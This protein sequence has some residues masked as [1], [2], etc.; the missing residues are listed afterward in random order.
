MFTIYL[1]MES[2]DYSTKHKAYILCFNKN[3][4]Y[5][6][7]IATLFKV[8]GNLLF[9]FRLETLLAG[10]PMIILFSH[11][12]FA[13]KAAA[14]FCFLAYLLFDMLLD[15]LNPRYQEEKI[16][17]V[18]M[19]QMLKSPK[20]IHRGDV[21][22][23]NDSFLRDASGRRLLLRGINVGGDSKIPALPGEDSH[24]TQDICFVGRPFPLS[25]ADEHFQRLQACGFTLVRLV[26]TWKAVEHAGPGQYDFAYLQ[27]LQELVQIG[28][29]YNMSFIID[30][31]QDVWSRFTGG[32]GAPR[33]T[34]ETV[35]F[36]VDKLHK[37]GAAFTQEGFILENTTS[38]DLPV[39]TWPSNHH[40]L[41]CGTM[42][43]LF[44][45][46]EDF[47]PEFFVS[48]QNI[49]S[50]LQ[51][52]FISAMAEVAFKLVDEENVIGFETMNEPNLGMI[53]WKDL[54][55][56][57]KFLLQGPTPTWFESFQLGVGLSTEVDYYDPSLI[58]AGRVML[59]KSYAQAWKYGV[60]CIWMHMG[61]WTIE[62]FEPKLLIPDFFKYRMKDGVR[63]E[64]NPVQDYFVPFVLKFKKRMQSM[65]RLG[66]PEYLIFINKPTDFESS[67][68]AN[69]PDN[70]D[71]D[72]DDSGL[73]WSPHW[74]DL[75]PV[76]TKS[77]RSWIGVARDQGWR[78]PLVFG[79]Q[80]LKAEYSRQLRLLSTEG[81]RIGTGI[82]TVLGE[83]GC[84]FDLE[85]RDMTVDEVQ[86]QQIAALD[87]QFSAVERALIS[88]CLWNYTASNSHEHG[89]GWNGENFSIYSKDAIDKSQPRSIFSGGRALRAV[90]R[91][92]A[93]RCPGTPIRMH[94]DITTKVFEFAYAHDA[95]VETGLVIFLPYYQYQEDPVVVVSDGSYQV[96]REFQT[97]TY[98]HSTAQ[99]IHHIK[100]APDA[101][102]IL[103]KKNV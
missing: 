3:M 84:P 34:L 14:A 56:P 33:W 30:P 90:V 38:Y 9:Q 102:N 88:S 48:G 32:S 103:Q 63:V 80:S 85:K 83:F 15:K 78:F 71:L 64:V 65:T 59:N 7:I 39:M 6:M 8:T 55:R 54:S 81:L 61:V 46:G 22:R 23:S 72:G 62:D 20:N 40:K 93:M 100:I 45:G 10:I 5:H 17:N 52:H 29:E 96:N 91:P 11:A 95:H 26:V 2:G 18:Q 49:Q 50:Y 12:M 1:N 86:S 98:Q 19:S 75:V 57:S 87:T 16:K 37:C 70:T 24:R 101:V 68:I 47:C 76:V 89:D 35:G 53:G 82:P 79:N 60:G 4:H 25:D 67:S 36:D 99:D 66:N 51:D 69:F 27:Y 41:A 43:S 31:H 44:F 21:H 42:F 58:K 28:A 97:L 77:F 74:Y 13:N 94:F 92:Y 73:V